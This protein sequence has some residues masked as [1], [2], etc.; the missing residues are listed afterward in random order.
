M[1]E[2]YMP[3]K[4]TQEEHVETMLQF[5]A[6]YGRKPM[7]GEKEMYRVWHD[8]LDP[9]KDDP[10]V[11]AMRQ[12]YGPKT[13]TTDEKI[14]A[15]QEF[16]AKHGRR[17]NTSEKKEYAIWRYIVWH[18]KDDSRVIALRQQYD[19]KTISLDDKIKMMEAFTAQ[20]H[21]RPL[22]SETEMHSIWSRMVQHV[23]KNSRIRALCDKY[24]AS[25]MPR[26]KG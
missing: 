12:K 24:G 15:M 13:L 14:E 11:I 25:A 16:T 17:P 20:H 22:P 10:R 19:A 9:G 5:T 4:M 26:V 3:T 2:K 23:K 21:R 6:R 8:M 18:H 1:R 7:P